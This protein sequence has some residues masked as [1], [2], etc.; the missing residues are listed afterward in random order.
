MCHENITR[1]I[2]AEL[3][4]KTLFIQEVLISVRDDCVRCF[5]ILSLQVGLGLMHVLLIQDKLS[6]AQENYWFGVFFVEN[7]A[8]EVSDRRVREF[9]IYVYLGI[10]SVVSGKK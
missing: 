5:R 3:H 6:G 10:T 2:P 1:I 8:I 7:T 9:F 4:N